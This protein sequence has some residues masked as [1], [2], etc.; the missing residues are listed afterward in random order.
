MLESESESESEILKMLESESESESRHTRNRASL[1]VTVYWS[2]FAT[3]NQGKVGAW[4]ELQNVTLK[5]RG[6]WTFSH[7]T[8]L[9]VT[10]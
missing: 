3:G 9:A 2:H 4:S 7:S 10:E 5:Y 8:D 1:V 6:Y